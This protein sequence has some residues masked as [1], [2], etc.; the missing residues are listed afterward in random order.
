MS[1]K[2]FLAEAT[3]QLADAGIETARLDVLVLLED[4]LGQNRASVLAH[5]DSQLTTAQTAQLHKKIM[6]RA[7]HVPL[8][9]IRG[10][11]AFYGRDF[12][13]S[14]HVLVP[15]PE[16]EMIIELLKK[17]PLSHPHIAD[18]GTGSGCLAITAAL[19]LPSA[20]VVAYDI[21][22][23][24]LA[25]AARNAKLLHATVQCRQSDLL[26]QVDEHYDVL[27]ANLPYVPELFAINKAAMFEP[28]LAL[29]SGADGLDLFKRFWQEVVTKAESPQYI[30]TES[31]PGQHHAVAMLAR[32]A[33]YI[34]YAAKDLV[35]AFERA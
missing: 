18:I 30:I 3:K 31:L 29:F 24:A 4:E 13:V 9:Y 28:K 2:D 17:L 11:V 23:P 32:N 15:R 21:D 25:V 14:E 27:L 26:Q 6:Q 7:T 5:D 10:R 33:G 12:I 34:L 19:E 1:V 16:S 22:S 20:T 8:A 35:Q